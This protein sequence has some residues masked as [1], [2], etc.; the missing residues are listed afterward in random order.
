MLFPGNEPLS[1]ASQSSEFP[2]ALGEHGDLPGHGS[3]S[4]TALEIT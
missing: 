3:N 1:L 4:K 2:Q